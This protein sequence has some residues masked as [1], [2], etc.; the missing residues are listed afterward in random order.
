M[1]T[2]T[3]FLESLGSPRNA[4][5]L[6]SDVWSGV[7][8]AKLFQMASSIRSPGF[9]TSFSMYYVDYDMFLSLLSS[10]KSAELPHM[11]IRFR[12]LMWLAMC[13]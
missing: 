1:Y 6:G 9:S 12:V 4:F 7:E 8:T 13:R 3:P 2:L 5:I 10:F 11:E